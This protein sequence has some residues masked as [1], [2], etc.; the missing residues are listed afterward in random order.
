M[1]MNEIF[2]RSD[3]QDVVITSSRIPLSQIVFFMLFAFLKSVSAEI[4]RRKFRMT[5]TKYFAGD[6][7]LAPA[8]EIVRRR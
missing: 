5:F 8:N 1:L 6:R 4:P 3:E 7:I 2:R